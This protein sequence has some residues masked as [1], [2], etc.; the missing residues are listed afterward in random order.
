MK[1]LIIF[2]LLLSTISC[3]GGGNTYLPPAPPPPIDDTTPPAAPRVVFVYDPAMPEIGTSDG[4][5]FYQLATDKA[6]NGHDGFISISDVLYQIDATGETVTTSRLP[7]APDKIAINGTDIWCFEDIYDAMTGKDYTRIML[8]SAQY[9]N[10]TANQFTVAEAMVTGNNDIIIQDTGDRY[11]NITDP[12]QVINYASHGGI[13]IHSIDATNRR[14][15]IDNIRV[16]FSTNYFFSAKEWV[17]A[18]GVYYSWNGYTWDGSVLSEVATKLSD[19]TT[20]WY[21]ERP[22]LRGVGS[23]IEHSEAVTYWIECNT[24][25][26]YRHTP[27]I[28]S[29][30]MVIQIYQGDGTRNSGQ[31]VYRDIKPVMAGDCLYYTWNGTVWK[32]DFSS[33]LVSTFAA[34]VDI[35]AM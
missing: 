3:G 14:A 7:V 27:S 16:A 32:Y 28:D 15:N 22:V 11:R 24:G 6:A 20:L 25:W 33:G 2:T 31:I 30:E 8:N 35:W 23:R 1:K 12:T 17:E 18:D 19:F 29:L 13:N 10:W 4:T 21:S 26:L 5:Y 34:G 9:G